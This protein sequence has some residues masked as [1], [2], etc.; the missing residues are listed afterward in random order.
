MIQFITC[1][2]S[3]VGVSR[4][5]C[6]CPPGSPSSL[7]LRHLFARSSAEQPLRTRRDELC[8]C[9]SNSISP[10]SGTRWRAFPR[11]SAVRRVRDEGRLLPA[12][13]PRPTAARARDLHR[14]RSPL[15]TAAAAAAAL[16]VSDDF[17]AFVSPSRCPAPAAS[18]C[19]L[20]FRRL[21]VVL[22]LFL[23]FQNQHRMAVLHGVVR[24][25]ADHAHNLRP[26]VPVQPV[27]VEQ[28]LILLL[29]PPALF[30]VVVQVVLPPATALL[31]PF[32]GGHLGGDESR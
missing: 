25:A 19:R 22:V 6:G 9:F 2:K 29:R 21:G 26:L 15:P 8:T 7:R 10:P 1:C 17:F 11:G 16:L 30:G 23:L 13:A 24:A 31:R 3:T 18:A 32:A 27:A 14:V 28:D 12:A 4:G 5:E 20:C